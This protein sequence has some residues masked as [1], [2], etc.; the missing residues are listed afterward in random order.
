ML[1]VLKKLKT[2]GNGKVA[3]VSLEDICERN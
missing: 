2:T 1:N 3:R